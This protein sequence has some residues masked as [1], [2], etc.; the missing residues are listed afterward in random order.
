MA[1]KTEKRKRQAG[2]ARPE[3]ARF[4]T[5]YHGQGAHRNKKAYRR[6]EKHRLQFERED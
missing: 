1:K 6:R 5:S 4:C 2:I 3:W